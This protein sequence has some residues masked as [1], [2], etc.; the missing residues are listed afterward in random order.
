ML[1]ETYPKLLTL[2]DGTSVAIR[3]LAQGDFEQLFSFFG[4]L[5]E[6]DRLFLR[7]DVSDPE[8]VR[9]WTEE[10]DL[11]RVI[12]LVALDGDQ[13]VANGSLHIMPHAWIRHVGHIRLV[14]ARS[15][16][17]KGLGKLITR[18]LVTLAQE[19]DLEKIQAHVIEDNKA[20]IKMFTAVGFEVAAVLKGMVKDRSW[21]SRNLA[22]MVNDV[23]NLTRIMEEWIQ[24]SMQPGFRAPG[25]G[26]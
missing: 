8:L 19:R 1:T 21:K 7:D 26:E 12:P 6:E 4:A 3:P 13:I 22:I 14:T 9:R 11:D 18:E 5:H 10:V 17:Q 24:Q 23:A 15:H 20:A 25:G 16:R 2:K